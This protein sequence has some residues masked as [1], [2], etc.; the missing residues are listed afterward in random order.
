MLAPPEISDAELL[1]R[2]VRSARSPEHRGRHHRW[3]AVMHCF[4]VGSTMAYLLCWR[5]GLDPN[6][7]VKS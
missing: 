4:A 1:R 6:E 5:F 3:V 2:A 7:M